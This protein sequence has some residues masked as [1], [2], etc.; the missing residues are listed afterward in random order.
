M[1]EKCNCFSALDPQSVDDIVA[2][3]VTKL[4]SEDKKTKTRR[5]GCKNSKNNFKF[6][7]WKIQI[8]LGVIKCKKGQEESINYVDQCK[9]Q[10]KCGGA[11]SK[12]EGEEL[13]QTLTP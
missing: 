12:E 6:N 7:P 2:C 3:D 4:S 11:G 8:F 9:A 1:T 5:N 13:L 10:L